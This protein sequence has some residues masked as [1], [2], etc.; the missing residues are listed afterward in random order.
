MLAKIRSMAV[1]GI[2]AYEITIE[3]DISDQSERRALADVLPKERYTQLESA[4]KSAIRSNE[5]AKQIKTLWQDPIINKEKL[6]E[7]YSEVDKS[8]IV[9][10]TGELWDSTV[11]GF[12]SYMD[13]DPKKAIEALKEV[14]G[15]S[16]H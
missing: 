11:D 16:A 6:K 4:Y 7:L 5:F 9:D 12:E 2:D 14:S 10:L 1:L 8:K 15:V 13:K 3:A